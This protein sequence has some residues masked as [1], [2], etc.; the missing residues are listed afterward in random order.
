M[1]RHYDGEYMKRLI[2]K[3]RN[4][5]REDGVDIGIWA[6]IIVGFP[7]ESE[8]DFIDTYNLVKEYK[9]T[10]LHAFPFS[11]HTMG[12]SVPAGKFK[13]QVDEKVK[14][15]RMNRLL[16][17]W[18]ENREE[19]IRSQIGKPLKVLIE[20]KSWDSFSGWSEN[21]I[22]C[23]ESNFEIIGGDMKKNGIVVGRLR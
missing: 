12:E 13:E 21:Y 16:E 9:I 23:N 15:D 2:K 19:F 17:L 1:A 7:G 6:D 5:K 22:E 10:K 3:T 4:I 8:E 18:E 14:K 20:K 11:A